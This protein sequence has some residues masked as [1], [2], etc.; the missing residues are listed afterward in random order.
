MLRTAVDFQITD[1]Y[2][3]LAMQDHEFYADP[4]VFDY[5]Q[6]RVG[7]WFCGHSRKLRPYGWALAFTS[8]AVLFAL[9]AFAMFGATLAGRMGGEG[10][11][12]W[13]QSMAQVITIMI[14]LLACQVLLQ[15]ALRSWPTGITMPRRL[16]RLV[17]QC[18]WEVPVMALPS[19][20]R[21]RHSP[22]TRRPERRKASIASERAAVQAFFSGVRAAGVNVSIAR[23]LFNAGIRTPLQLC[24]ASDERLLSIRGVGPVTVCKLRTQFDRAA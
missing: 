21:P 10:Q 8:M 17:R 19:S 2:K 12:A 23:A 4:T 22:R 20:S 5:W 1:V 18:G 13:N 11:M 16:R 15:Q 7:D 6:R 24:S 14:A 3:V 9:T